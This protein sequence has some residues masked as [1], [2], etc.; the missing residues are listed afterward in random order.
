VAR[1]STFG[2][3]LDLWKRYR[4]V[5]TPCIIKF[6]STQRLPNAVNTALWYAFLKLRSGDL[7]NNSS[8]YT[9]KAVPSYR[10]TSSTSSL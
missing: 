6:R 5:S 3:D 10:R 7:A 1:S 2:A 8:G 4:D 9:E